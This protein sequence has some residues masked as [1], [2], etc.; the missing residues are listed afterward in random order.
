[1]GGRLYADFAQAFNLTGQHPEPGFPF[2]GSRGATVVTADPS[3]AR[4]FAL[5]PVSGRLWASS[6]LRRAS[7][8]SPKSNLSWSS[9]SDEM[10]LITHGYSV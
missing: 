7:L 3:L 9:F 4:A 2:L 6:S 5:I 8:R 10:F 1:M